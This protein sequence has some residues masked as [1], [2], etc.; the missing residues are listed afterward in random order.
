MRWIV[1]RVEQASFYRQLK[2]ANLLTSGAVILLSSVFLLA[3][4]AWLSVQALL[5]RARTD[6]MMTSANL[7]VAMVFHDVKS[8]HDILAFLAASRAIKSAVV[9]DKEGQLFA[10]YDRDGQGQDRSHMALRPIPDHAH[11]R[12]GVTELRW[13][14]PFQYQDE[15]LGTMVV[16]GDLYTVYGGLLSY[17]GM[18]LFLLGVSL[19]LANLALNRMQARIT[20]P[21]RHLSGVAG[22]ILEA[23][24]FS[25]RVPDNSANEIGQLGQTFNGILERI[26]RRELELTTEI[27]ERRRV[28]EQLD[29]L[30]HF[31]NVTGLHNRH[32]F[33]ERLEQTVAEAVAAGTRAALIFIDL[34]NFKNFNDTLGHATGDEVLRIVAQ[35]VSHT[36]RSDDVLSRVGG[37]EFAIIVRDLPDVSVA[38]QVAK[39][40]LQALAAPV[41]INGR[42]VFISASIGIS[43]CPDD[44]TDVQDLLKY[45]DSA[46]YYAKNSGK[47]AYSV[48]A[49]RM[50]RATERRFAIEVSLRRALERNELR[51]LYQPKVD[52]LRRRII[53]AEALVRWLS[54]EL[55]L[56]SPHEFIP[57]AEETGTIIQIGEW[58]LQQ[59]CQQLKAWHEQGHEHLQI[60][61]NLSGRQLRELN[62]VDKV[63][64]VL[65]RSAIAPGALEL[66]LTESMLMDAGQQTIA[67]LRALKN[68]GIRLAIDDFGTGYSSMS[69]LKMFPIDTL[70]I[71]QSFVRD[72]PGNSDDCA[73]VQA[74]IAM[75]R[76]LQ[77]QVVAEGIEKQ[78]QA[79]F[80]RVY[81]CVKAQGML[82]GEPMTAS[83]FEALLA[84]EGRE[85][86]SSAPV[87]GVGRHHPR[88]PK[89]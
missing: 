83:A 41:F 69:Y 86:V 54:P 26:Q 16:V 55:G 44:A 71:D 12:L 78:N 52:T 66:E 27:T 76:N 62:V 58:V 73:I 19:S 31:D 39:K 22:Q 85:P 23:G 7:S 84:A 10:S 53:G 49:P 4:Q 20:R 75:G 80:L 81:G 9:Y 40:F 37:D 30:A 68:T 5:D 59:A 63:R 36:V 28:Q 74:I 57:L 64:E 70:K 65:E 29:F 3:L 18:L 60:A 35:R 77:L 82:Y 89:L 8:A 42:E 48:F 72:L 24:D 33:N 46:M 38:E 25:I 67:K 21:L 47:N 1:R 6:A 61:V 45:A 14:Q 15:R 32:Y 79:D 34:D 43:V 50:R 87:P 17:I 13:Y 56:L 11:Y 88:T 2:L 51:L